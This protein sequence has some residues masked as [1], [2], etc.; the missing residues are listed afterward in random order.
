M[1]FHLWSSL[2]YSHLDGSTLADS[3]SNSKGAGEGVVD[4][5]KDEFDEDDVTFIPL[6]WPR[7]RPGELYNGN[8]PEW[9]DFVKFAKDRK[10]LD[11]L[12]AELENVV[13][14]R[15]S[16]NARYKHL[17]GEQVRITKSWLLVQFPYR[18]PP[19]YET[20]GIEISDD[21]VVLKSKTVPPEQGRLIVAALFPIAVSSA[22]GQAASVFFSRKLR[23]VKKALGVDE[24][25]ANDAIMSIKDMDVPSDLQQSTNVNLSTYSE[26]EKSIYSSNTEETRLS[27]DTNT[28]QTQPQS[29]PSRL[30]KIIS[31]MQAF[32]TQYRDSDLYVAY[33]TFKLHLMRHKMQQRTSV[34]HR[35]VF[36]FNGPVGLIGSK[37]LCR[38]EVQGEYD[39]ARAK[40]SFISMKLKDFSYISQEPL[41]YSRSS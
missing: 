32:P 33:L 39:P 16:R 23:R 15:I 17:L 29:P 24:D 31:L 37:G 18:A 12:R 35:G 41:G 8:D 36:Y 38:L 7:L 11:S 3:E 27:S 40:W 30:P 26:W 20:V 10:R 14:T 28:A 21:A 4:T 34:P 5:G 13:R 22:M 6:S 19:S 1:A 2:L 25:P 9:K